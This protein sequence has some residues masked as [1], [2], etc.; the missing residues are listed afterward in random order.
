[1]AL[2]NMC[3]PDSAELFD[4]GGDHAVPRGK[5]TVNDLTDMV[6]DKGYFPS[7]MFQFTLAKVWILPRLGHLPQKLDSVP[8][9][10]LD[11]VRGN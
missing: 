3:D 2:Y 8:G 7:Y 4:H 5:Q 11:S 10:A 6:R 1:M 9:S